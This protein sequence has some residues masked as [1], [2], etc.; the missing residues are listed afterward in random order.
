MS[1]PD[2]FNRL[3]VY[4][5]RHGESEQGTNS[6]YCGHTDLALS[7]RG[8]EQSQRLCN[9]LSRKPL[10]AVYSSDLSRALYAARL[11]A[12][13]H[14]LE[15][16]IEPA[17]REIFM[18]NWEGRPVAEISSEH[19]DKL[20]QLFRAPRR[21]RYPGGESFAEFEHRVTEALRRMLADHESGEIT[22][23]THGGVCRVI[24][25]STL[26]LAPKNWL[27]I[28]QDFGCLNV[29]DWY[30]GLPLVK[31]VNLVLGDSIQSLCEEEDE[32]ES[33][34]NSLSVF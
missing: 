16:I 8:I 30:D 10:A 4:L 23:V 34:N 11:I 25:S 6:V 12:S 26:E 22:I 17:L 19:P 15:P 27:R 3:R 2:Q 20:A 5:L 24:I 33:G 21:F 1:K 32:T 28:S 29:I 9:A 18:G 14:N 7:A 13:A 31:R